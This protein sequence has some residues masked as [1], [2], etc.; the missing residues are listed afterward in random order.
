MKRDAVQLRRNL[1]AVCPTLTV[2]DL[3]MVIECLGYELLGRGI[4]QG[5]TLAGISRD[6]LG[7]RQPLEVRR[8]ALVGLPLRERG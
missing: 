7:F 4:W 8:A 2:D 6:L 3:A 5:T 1:Q